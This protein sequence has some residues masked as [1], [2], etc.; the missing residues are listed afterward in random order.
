MDGPCRLPYQPTYKGQITGQIDVEQYQQ[1]ITAATRKIKDTPRNPAVWSARSGLLSSLGFPDLATGD[2]HKALQLTDTVA[3]YSWLCEYLLDAHAYADAL[4][5]YKTCIENH[6]SQ[7][8]SPIKHCAC[9]IKEGVARMGR[10]TDGLP[11]SDRKALQSI[12]HVLVRDYPWLTQEQKQRSTKSRAQ[13]TSEVKIKSQ[14]YA[15]LA[16]SS[17]R[18]TDTDIW[19]VNAS[20]KIP[21]GQLIMADPALFVVVDSTNTLGRGIMRR[22]TTCALPLRP[23]GNKKGSCKTCSYCSDA[24]RSKAVSTFHHK[25]C[26]STDFI[27][28]LLHP[29]VPPRDLR[30]SRTLRPLPQRAYCGNQHVGNAINRPLTIATIEPLTPN[31]GGPETHAFN[32]HDHIIYPNQLLTKQV[33]DVYSNHHW[34]TWVL[35]TIRR[36]IDNNDRG[37]FVHGVYPNVAMFN[38]SCKPNVSDDED[39]GGGDMEGRAVLHLRARRDV[40]KGEELF[41]RY[42]GDE[43][44]G[45]EE[46][47]YALMHWLGRDCRCGRC[48]REER[49]RGV[50]ALGVE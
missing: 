32:Y 15:V 2:A 20:K 8:G 13:V 21:A 46:R 25:L 30:P 40:E 14:D 36:R 9:G 44:D 49:E 10:M 43:E 28:P 11:H 16:V 27:F 1:A 33:I 3:A 23:R 37:Q 48:V 22:C 29:G 45:L 18:G 50:A 39:A 38:H 41:I 26:P 35:L 42:T 17:I 34:D 19:G 4:S 31:R 5:V 6:L 47:R 12:G 7:A 24:C